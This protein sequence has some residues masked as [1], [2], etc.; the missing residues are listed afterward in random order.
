MAALLIVIAV[1]V[2]AAGALTGLILLIVRLVDSSE[3][4]PYVPHAWQSMTP[5]GWYPDIS[6]PN[7]LRFFDG[8]QWTSATRQTH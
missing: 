4:E 5:P 1:G 7:M 8:Q 6:D 2:F 3:S